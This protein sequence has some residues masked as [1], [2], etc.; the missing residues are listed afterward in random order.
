HLSGGLSAYQAA[1]RDHWL[2]S[3]W[4]G[5]TLEW[6]PFNIICVGYFF[7]LGTGAGCLF[8]VLGLL[9]SFEGG[10]WRTLARSKRV[11][12]FAAWLIPAL[13]FF[14]LIY[15][16][17]IQTGHSLIYLPALLLLLLPSV[18]CSLATLCRG[19]SQLALNRWAVAAVAALAVTNLS[20]F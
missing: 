4:H 17:P 14:I 16:H 6:L 13:S 3:N 8:L 10:S 15:S 2:N 5:L 20:V 9:F 1:L 11:Q 18:R 12:F 19:G 7:L